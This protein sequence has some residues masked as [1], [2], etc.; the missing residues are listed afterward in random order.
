MSMS[1]VYWYLWRSVA[2]SLEVS[3][4]WV[5]S[6]LILVLGLKLGSSARVASPHTFPRDDLKKKK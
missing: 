5:V 2:G 6:P 4:R 3:Y 1:E